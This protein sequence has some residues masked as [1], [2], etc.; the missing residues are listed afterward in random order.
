MLDNLKQKPDDPIIELLM[1]A[2]A[3]TSPNVVDLSAGVFKDQQGHTPILE[4]V[5]KAEP[6]RLQNENTRT[7]QGIIGDERFNKAIAELVLGAANPL[8]D[9][10]RVATLHTVAGSAAVLMAGQII[11]EACDVPLVW[12]G[13][14]TWANHYPLLKTAGVDVK[15][16]PYYDTQN[17]SIQFDAMLSTLSGLPRG[18]VILLH[19]CCHNPSGADL[20]HQQWDELADLMATKELMPFVDVAYQGLGAGID[21]DAYGWRLLAS[22]VPEMLI[23]FSCSK[24]FSLYRDRVGALISISKDAKA[25]ACTRSNLMSL[26]RATYSMPAAHGAF[27]VAEIL[28]DKQLKAMWIEELTAMRERINGVRAGFAQAMAER[29][30]AEQFDFVAKQFGMFS[31]LGINVEQITKLRERYSLYMLQSSRI[32]IAGLTNNNLSYVADS[33][34]EVLAEQD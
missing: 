34:A 4:A 18:S 17:N 2:R 6:R 1:R 28:H 30:F 24:N 12:A 11:R 15:E 23:A 32:S 5:K 14:P 3:D 22:K 20:S 31:F 33:L 19:G 27:L 7:Y 21:E 25:A 16:F 10:G 13:K 26:S 29:G 8:F 9:E